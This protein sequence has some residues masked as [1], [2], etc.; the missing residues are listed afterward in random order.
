MNF[1]VVNSG[2]FSSNTIF[3]K[4]ENFASAE[5]K[6]PFVLGVLQHRFMNEKRSTLTCPPHLAA[7][8]A[9]PV[10]SKAQ[11]LPHLLQAEHAGSFVLQPSPRFGATKAGGLKP[12]TECHLHTREKPDGRSRPFRNMRT[13]I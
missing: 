3:Q 10:D 12:G 8:P 4:L 5:I 7:S 9:E 11:K 1:S 13:Y 2:F 6:K